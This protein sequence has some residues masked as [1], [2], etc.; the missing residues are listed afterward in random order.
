VAENAV[1]SR[2]GKKISKKMLDKWEEM[3]ALKD[4]EVHQFRL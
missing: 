4:Q 2:T 3:D 1:F